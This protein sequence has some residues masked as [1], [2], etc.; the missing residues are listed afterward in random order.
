MNVLKYGDVGVASNPHPSAAIP[1]PAQL[2]SRFASVMA[3][4]SS[5]GQRLILATTE[6]VGHDLGRTVRGRAASPCHLCLCIRHEL[7]R[8]RP[9][10]LR[11]LVRASDLRQHMVYIESDAVAGWHRR[12]EHRL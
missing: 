2:R 12:V 4:P 10:N 6:A 7:K 8:P 1:D 11:G 3:K 9:A 5:C